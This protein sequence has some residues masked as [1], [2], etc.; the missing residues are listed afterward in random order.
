MAA[1][2]VNFDRYVVQTPTCMPS[3]ASYLTGQYP[4]ELGI[5]GNGVPLPEDTETLP[6]LISN[7]DHVTANIGKLHFLPHANR[8][9][10]ERHPDYGFDHLEVS[11][12]PGCYDDAYRAWVRSKAPEQAD[13][14][15]VGLPP[16]A[17]T[18]QDAVGFDD[19]IDHPTPRFEPGARPFPADAELTHSAFVADRT[20]EFLEHHQ[21]DPFLCVAGFYSPHSPWVAPER[22]LDQYDPSEF[23]LPTFPT[24]MEARRPLEPDP[25]DRARRQVTFSDE[26]LRSVRHGYYAMISE[27]DHHVGRVLEQL[28]RLGIG[29]DTIVIF[30]AD[31]GEYL[32]E[33]LHYGKGGVGPDSVVRVPFL[34]RWPAGIDRPGRTEHGIVEAVDLVPTILDCL[35]VPIPPALQGN[36]LRPALRDD[37]GCFRDAA[38]IEG[39]SGG[40]SDGSCGRA[41]RGERYKYVFR[42]D[43]TE[44]LYDLETDPQ[45][46]H[47]VAGKSDYE[48]PLQEMRRRLLAR[49]VEVESGGERRRAWA[50]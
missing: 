8:D 26:E 48:D 9:H 10:R 6:R 22:F 40:E 50:Y 42:R 36:S 30:T 46:Y 17:K 15:S 3:R 28:D 49:M 19:G 5:Y 45:E 11:D 34:V 47:D 2:G 1:E 25:D 18:W 12:E 33:H 27:V 7:T 31:H 14:I 43:G 24:S 44:E 13:Q 37:G 35:E 29:E 21:D 38:L 32:G 41:L 16:M 20:M 39:S 4:S 23:E